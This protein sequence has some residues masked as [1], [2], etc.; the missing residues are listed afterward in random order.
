MR[1]LPLLLF[2]PL[3]LSP[4]AAFACINSMTRTVVDQITTY[5]LD[6]LHF[7]V[8]LAALILMR[9]RGQLQ[10]G[11]VWDPDLTDPLPGRPL[12]AKPSQPTVVRQFTILAVCLLL[13]LGFGIFASDVADLRNT[14]LFTSALA[15]IAIVAGAVSLSFFHVIPNLLVALRRAFLFIAII[16]SLGGAADAWSGEQKRTEQVSPY[17]PIAA[18]HVFF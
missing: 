9:W 16:M 12:A 17:E 3:A 13:S 4:T 5:P 15:S 18:P 7:G 8:V 10:P 2:V 14:A 1:R 6:F 11:E